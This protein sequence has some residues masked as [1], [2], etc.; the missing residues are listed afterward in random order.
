MA[1]NSGVGS[2]QT[3]VKEFIRQ[4]VF[5]I[6]RYQRGYAWREK[7]VSDFLEDVEYMRK[8]LHFDEGDAQ[9]SVYHYLGNIVVKEDG[10]GNNNDFV[11]LID[12]QQRITTTTVLLRCIIDRFRLLGQHDAFDDYKT[13]EDTERSE[14]NDVPPLEKH[15]SW[16]ADDWESVYISPPGRDSECRLMVDKQNRPM[17]NSLVLDGIEPD[18]I[19]DEDSYDHLLVASGDA[20]QRDTAPKRRLYEAKRQI[21]N[22]I[23]E[24]E[25]E[26]GDADRDNPYEELYTYFVE[27]VQTLGKY[28]HLTEYSIENDVEAGRLFE[29][30]NNRG[31]GITLWD[32]I[33]SYLIYRCDDVPNSDEL[34]DSIYETF[35][36]V[37]QTLTINNSYSD[38]TIEHFFKAHWHLFTGKDTK[39]YEQMKS[40]K[41]YAS[42]DRTGQPLET[43]IRAYL[44][45]LENAAESFRAM[46]ETGRLYSEAKNQTDLEDD[47]LVE[48]QD[49]IDSINQFAGISTIAPIMIAMHERLG[50]SKRL[51]EFIRLFDSYSFRVYQIAKVEK[52]NKYRGTLHTKAIRTYWMDGGLIS[53]T[54]DEIFGEQY[55]GIGE[56]FDSEPNAVANICRFLE[57]KIEKKT[58]DWKFAQALRSRNVMN[59]SDAP[60]TD[61]EGFRSKADLKFFLYAYEK[62]LRHEDG[63]RTTYDSVPPFQTWSREGIDIEHIWAEE[64]DEFETDEDREDH[65]EY[66]QS[67]GNLALLKHRDNGE[68]GNLPYNQK[69]DKAYNTGKQPVKMIKRLKNYSA[70]DGWDKKRINQ[71]RDDI[72]ESAL[73]WWSCPSHAVVVA[74]SDSDA[75]SNNGSIEKA[76][77]QQFHENHSQSRPLPSVEVITSDEPVTWPRGDVVDGCSC[78]DESPP[79]EQLTHLSVEDGD[80]KSQCHCGKD[81]PSIP[82]VYFEGEYRADFEDGGED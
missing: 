19:S 17:Y 39:P 6:P 48:L 40:S 74:S 75:V 26:M 79:Y 70:R 13:R 80:I 69:Y 20:P 24:V 57:K 30:V 45:S 47:E 51:L 63:V 5:E 1:D 27:F 41:E 77:R 10:S 22:W 23:E 36:Q 42:R 67:L 71:R 59:D 38:E 66:V 9:E 81:V 35:G 15:P 2:E 32:E 53:W 50:A 72:I 44:E 12:G 4:Y 62:Y 34:T 28:F 78:L 73:D 14:Q 7:Q 25:N 58:P 29:V 49:R 11:D 21:L 43:W 65:E 60:G 37:I 33:K 46:T 8:K 55:D 56:P 16:H 31:K 54:P 52:G 61:W 82:L 3:S 68:I 76:V 64:L 18:R